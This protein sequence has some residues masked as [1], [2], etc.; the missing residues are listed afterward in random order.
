MG[1]LCRSC[2]GIPDLTLN[3]GLESIYSYM[4]WPNAD[5]LR[6][7]VQDS[8]PLCQLFLRQKWNDVSHPYDDVSRIVNKGVKTGSIWIRRQDE[9]PDSWSVL[10]IQDGPSKVH[11]EVLVFEPGTLEFFPPFESIPFNMGPSR[12]PFLRGQAS[13]KR[14]RG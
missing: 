13:P 11:G 12:F 2:R 5:A 1:C 10:E 14:N 6:L 7:S 9:R 8:C 3:L 4:V